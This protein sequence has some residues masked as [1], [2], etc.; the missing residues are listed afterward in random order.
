M[1]IL[2]ET[3]SIFQST[4]IDQLPA[5]ARNVLSQNSYGATCSQ[6]IVVTS[7]KFRS[8]NY[9]EEDKEVIVVAVP[10]EALIELDPDVVEMTIFELNP[11]DNPSSAKSTATVD[12]GID[13]EEITPNI[14]Y[15]VLLDSKRVA[16]ISP[17]GSKVFREIDNMFSELFSISR[18]IS[19]ST[20]RPCAKW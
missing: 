16:L 9:R 7:A 10:R 17:D 15:H 2:M 1:P 20:L 5:N 18:G 13:A 6:K 8:R 3:R 4:L 14:K 11:Y 12:I 19:L